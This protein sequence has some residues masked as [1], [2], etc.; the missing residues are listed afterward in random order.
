MTRESSG[1]NM[2]SRASGIQLRKPLCRLISPKIFPF[3]IL[4]F[5]LTQLIMCYNMFE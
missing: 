1:V 5:C 4:L 3:G 2:M